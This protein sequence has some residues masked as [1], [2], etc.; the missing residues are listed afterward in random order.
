MGDDNKK[1]YEFLV[2][3]TEGAWGMIRCDAEDSETAS[4]L[5]R[6]HLI[7]HELAP[8]GSLDKYF[9]ITLWQP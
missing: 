9:S 7:D 3:D 8:M 6:Q 1:T 5:A 4:K 2:T